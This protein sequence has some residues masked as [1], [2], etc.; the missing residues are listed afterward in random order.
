M[1]QDALA[2]PYGNSGRQM[3]IEFASKTRCDWRW[4]KN[5]TM[6]ELSV[7]RRVEFK[8]ACLVR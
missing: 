4:I 8:L 5:S 6:H 2:V 1:A 3:V 7:R